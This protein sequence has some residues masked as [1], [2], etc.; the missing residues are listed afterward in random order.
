MFPQFQKNHSFFNDDEQIQ[1][2]FNQP[3]MQMGKNGETYVNAI[4]RK[5]KIVGLLPG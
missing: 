2:S 5:R 1:N 4:S 3:A